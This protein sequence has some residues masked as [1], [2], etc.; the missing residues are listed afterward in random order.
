VRRHRGRLAA[1]CLA[2]Q[3]GCSAMANA[4]ATGTRSMFGGQSSSKRRTAPAFG[5]GSGTRDQQS[6]VFVSQEHAKLSSNRDSPGP[7]YQLTPAVG[8]QAASGN[9][10]APQWAFGTAQRFNFNSKVSTSL[11]GPGQYDAHPGVGTQVSSKNSS[12]PVFGFGSSDR[13][14]MAKVFIAEEHNKALYGA[15]SPGP[16]TYTLRGAVGKQV[17]SRTKDEPT[18]VFGSSKRFVYDH[19]KRAAVS[20]GPGTYQAT[21][22][23][24]TQVVSTKPSTPR[25]G[26]GTSNRHHQEKVYLTVEHE[27]SSAGRD[28]P[29]PGNYLMMPG[30]GSKQPESNIHS[31]ASW[32]FG[33]AQR[34]TKTKDG[35]GTPGPG[36]YV[37]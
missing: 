26:F 35:T 16:M 21:D 34:F 25:F 33:T 27:R 14:M 8:T 23:V 19:V 29:G 4:G 1:A 24:G 6:K 28:S 12:A 3:V 15:G 5:F 13:E 22:A 18:W 7:N 31:A 9:K 37:I 10:T 2:P 20:P 32:G 30:A 17:H 36:S 11:P